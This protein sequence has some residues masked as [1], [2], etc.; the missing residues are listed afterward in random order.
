MTTLNFKP[1]VPVFDANIRVGDSYD[2]PSPC[3]N[4]AALLAEMDRHGIARAVIYHAQTEEISPI[5]GNHFLETWLGDARLTPQWS[6][7]PTAASLAQIERLHGQNRVSS[8]RLHDTRSAGLP[9]RPWAYDKLLTW[10]STHQ[11]PL[12]IPLPNTDADELVTTLQGHP[13]LVTVLV[14]AH[15]VHHL[16]VRPLLAALPNA[17]LELSRYEPIGEME[18][19]RDEFGAR[20][21]L[22]GSWYPRYAMGTMLFYLHHTNLSEDELALVCAGNLER[23]LD[24]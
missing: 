24:G 21:L 23:I 7:L 12:W 14:G 22:Y 5:D 16:Q 19:L 9:F 18:A 11:I 3:P 17:Y 1:R 10:L 15:Y 6:V 13:E 20:R 8:V 4:Q 2:A